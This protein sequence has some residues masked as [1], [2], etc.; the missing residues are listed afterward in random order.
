MKTLEK[1]V[2][3][4]FGS[5]SILYALTYGIAAYS[6]PAFFFGPG[7]PMEIY[8]EPVHE[9]SIA[10]MRSHGTNT[11]CLVLTWLLFTRG[12][13]TRKR[14]FTAMLLS[15]QFVILPTM[16]RVMYDEDFD[17]RYHQGPWLA[18]IVVSLLHIVFLVLVL[19]KYPAPRIQ[20]APITNTD[21][22][23]L[24]LLNAYAAFF[25]FSRLLLGPDPKFWDT[26]K[27][28]MGVFELEMKECA[29]MMATAMVPIVYFLTFDAWWLPIFAYKMNVLY[30]ILALPVMYKQCYDTG[31]FGKPRASASVLFGHICFMTFSLSRMG[32]FKKE[33]CGDLE[34]KKRVSV[35]KAA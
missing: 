6:A 27:L 15:A 28:E 25:C 8:K 33:T 4:L 10:Y 1:F 18:G 32:A 22:I 30:M 9:I 29:Y 21:R 11:L 13:K 14:A 19:K 34:S 26:T 12:N 24:T 20:E 17:D 3:K 35:G 16:L 23:G 5:L 2:Y 7:G 31:G